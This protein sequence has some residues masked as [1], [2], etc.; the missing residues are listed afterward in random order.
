MKSILTLLLLGLTL[1]NVVADDLINGQ[2]LPSGCSM[3]DGRISCSGRF[4]NF[5]NYN[6][7]NADFTGAH[8]DQPKFERADLTGADFT[9]AYLVEPEFFWADLSNADFTNATIDD[10]RFKF[11]KRTNVNY[12]GIHIDK[13]ITWDC[14]SPLPLKTVYITPED[15]VSQADVDAAAAA[16]YAEGVASVTP[17]DGI[18]QADVDAAAAAATAACATGCHLGGCDCATI[19]TKWNEDGGCAHQLENCQDVCLTPESCNNVD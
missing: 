17:E 14:M 5:E 11:S 12:N 10:P 8:L 7:T 1:N 4:S 13:C 9:G 3:N 18:S 19:K 2:P 6:L 16:A 15:G